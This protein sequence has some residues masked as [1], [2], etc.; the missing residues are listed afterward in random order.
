MSGGKKIFGCWLIDSVSECF[1]SEFLVF[2]LT[3]LK[4]FTSQIKEM[5]CVKIY[6]NHYNILSHKVIY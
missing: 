2:S 3:N 6:G 1:L 4:P 5:L